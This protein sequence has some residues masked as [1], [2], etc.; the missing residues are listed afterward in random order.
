[1]Y[2]SVWYNNLVQPVFSPPS[3]VFV[4]VWAALY[5][6]IFA[7][8]I[9]YFIKNE[10]NK[11]LG[12][13]YFI[14]QLVLNIAWSPVFFILKSIKGALVI[15]ILL[16]IAVFLTI[17]KFYSVSKPAGVVLIPYFLWILF[18]TYLNIGYLVLN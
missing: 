3:S 10:E 16:D 2:N 13:F 11:G 18:A 15:V 14:L 9:L 7:A 12:Y 1:M 8:L 17:R 6:S 5:I 4:P